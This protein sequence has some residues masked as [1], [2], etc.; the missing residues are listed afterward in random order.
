MRPRCTSGDS[1]IRGRVRILGSHIFRLIL[2]G[3]M[4]TGSL[5]SQA[6]TA[7][8]VAGTVIASGK[9]CALA[10]LPHRCPATL[11]KEERPGANSLWSS[12]FSPRQENRSNG[13]YPLLSADLAKGLSALAEKDLWAGTPRRLN[14]G[15]AG[16]WPSNQEDAPTVKQANQKKNNNP[17]LQ[18]SP[19]HIFWVVPAF[20]VDY[21]KKFTPLTP[22]EKF[23][24]WAQS[25]YDP[26]GLGAGAAEAALEHS[27]RDGFCGYGQGWV[28]YGKCFGSAELDSD[29]SS[30]LGDYVFTVL[31][32]QDPRYFRLGQG[33]FGKRTW[34]A[35]TRVFVTYSDSGRTV[36]YTSALSGTL[37]AS[38]ASNLYY[39]QQDRGFGLT[40][41]RVAWDL[42][43]TFLYNGAAEFWPD[44]KQ[45]LHH[46]F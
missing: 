12:P 19:G 38:A 21:G 16:L 46:L 1:L 6:L 44:F 25:A 39:P 42:G 15:G 34:Y 30:F 36:F 9:P 27:P 33:S 35:F 31:M 40:M 18:G 24:E 13:C 43:N 8:S 5:Y 14:V 17:A 26:L 32:H 22:R 11:N 23:E 28:G 2:T 45:R 4:L 41:S 7:G 3:A 37:I 10:S 29:L 20:K